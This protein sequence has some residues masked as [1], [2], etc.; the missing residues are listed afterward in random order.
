MKAHPYPRWRRRLCAALLSACTL[1]SVA[2]QPLY[3]RTA[4][5]VSTAE[6]NSLDDRWLRML[7]LGL[8]DADGNLIE[9]TAFALA[10]GR[11]ADSISA[12]LTLLGSDPDLSM[13]ITVLGSG[14]T[15][16]VEELLYALSIEYQMQSLSGS[17]RALSQQS[18]NDAAPAAETMDDTLRLSVTCSLDSSSL[19]INF[20]LTDAAGNPA[21]SDS[22]VTFG[23][24]L[25]GAIDGVFQDLELWK[26][27]SFSDVCGINEYVSYTIPAGS[28]DAFVYYNL[29]IL[30]QRIEVLYDVNDQL[31]SQRPDLLSGPLVFTVQ[32][33][34]LQGAVIEKQSNGKTLWLNADTKTVAYYRNR[35]DLSA[36]SGIMSDQTRRDASSEVSAAISAASG[37]SFSRVSV[38]DPVISLAD[39]LDMDERLRMAYELGVT[40]KV[41]AR[42]VYAGNGSFSNT[43][44]APV[45]IRVF[46]QSG[47][48]WVECTYREDEHN[49]DQNTATH[50]E[51]IRNLVL[52]YTVDAN[53]NI[54]FPQ[55]AIGETVNDANGSINFRYVKAGQ[56][57]LSTG[58]AFTDKDAVAPSIVKS[59][60]QDSI[61][62]PGSSDLTWSVGQKIPIIVDIDRP[63][64]GSLS[65]LLGDGSAL[66]DVET[67]GVNSPELFDVVINRPGDDE[68]YK[69]YPISAKRTMLY[70]VKEF[71]NTSIVLSAVNGQY[72]SALVPTPDGFLSI[73]EIAYTGGTSPT[74]A[75]R[76]IR[77]TLPEHGITG[78]TVEM[79]D[80]PYTSFRFTASTDANTLYQQLFS[81]LADPSTATFSLVAV[82]DD[83]FANAVPFSI[84]ESADGQTVTL[85]AQKIFDAAYNTSVPHTVRMY[86]LRDGQYTLIRGT[87]YRFTQQQVTPAPADAF[88]I[89]IDSDTLY[90]TDAAAPQLTITRNG[91]RSWTYDSS[92]Q[93]YWQLSSEGIVFINDSLYVVPQKEGTVSITRMCRNGSNDT[94]LHTPCSNTLE[95]T[96][97]G[98]STPSIRFPA[99]A[100][101]FLTREG[102]DCTVRF[103]SNLASMAAEGDP[104]TL[105]LYENGVSVYTDTL[106]RLANSATIPGRFLTTLSQGET[107]AYTVTLQT[108]AAGK[109]IST[110]AGIIVLPQPV[111]ISLSLSAD[112]SPVKSALLDG[113]TLTVSWTVQ[114]LRGGSFSLTMESENES[115][116]LHS[117]TGA[118]ANGVYTGSADVT[119]SLH[120]AQALKEN[121]LLLARAKNDA[122]DA[123]GSDSA[124]VTVY[125]RDALDILVGGE[126]GDS[127]I[128]KN[129]PSDSGVSTLPTITNTAGKTLSG[130]DSAE[131]I[132]ALR[133]ELGLLESVSINAGQYS[134]GVLSDRIQWSVPENLQKI[135]TLNYRQGTMFEPLDSFP[136]LYYIPQTILTLCGLSD[137]TAEV[138]ASHN[139][140][141]A[142]SDTVRV[143]VETL[144]NKLYLFQFSPAAKTT[145]SYVD[146]KGVQKEL[147]SN[148]DGSLALYEPDGI[149]SDL[150]CYT[151]SGGEAYMGTLPHAA[152]RSGE[153][154]GVRGELYPL[155]A[156]SMRRAASAEIV[157]TKPDGSP[158]TGA[159]TLRGGVYRN[160][161]LAQNRDD[162]YCSMAR[163]TD[164]PGHPADQDGASDM[165]F[166]ADANGRVQLYL[167]VTQFVSANDPDPLGTREDIEYILELRADGYY[168]TL[169]TL[170]A[171]LT[172]SDVMRGGTNRVSLQE[173]KEEAFFIV[174]Q[175][176][177]YGTG[178]Q[179]PVTKNT[180]RVGPNLNYSTAVFSSTIMLWGAQASDGD[181]TSQLRLRDTR[182]P[183][184]SQTAV[185]TADA[186]YPF[187][188]IPLLENT[189]TLDETLF[190]YFGEDSLRGEYRIIDR[191]GG[192]IGGVLSVRPKFV[193]MLNAER[194]QDSDN[195]LALMTKIGAFGSVDGL[196]SSSDLLNTASDG[197]IDAAL[198]FVTKMGAETGVV[199]CV[200]T[201]TEDPARFTGYFWT[202]MNTLKM[203]DLDYDDN[204]I[205]I[206][207]N[208]LQMQLNDTFSISDFKSMADGSYFEDRSNLYGAIANGVIGLPVSL[209]LEGW[210]STEICFNAASGEW[211][212]L[213]TGGGLTAAA[214]MQYEAVKDIVVAP[215]IP[216]TYSVKLRGGVVVDFKTAI[217]YA[218]ELSGE[219][220]ADKAQSVNDYLTALR[221]N[222]YIELFG[223]LGRGK[224]GFTLKIGSFGTLQLNN[225]NRFLT[226]NYL[227]EEKLEGQ[228]LR[229]DGEIGVKFAIGIGFI[230]VEV[231]LVSVGLGKGWTFNGWD[232]INEYWNGGAEGHSLRM[233]VSSDP[234]YVVLSQDVVLQ[235]R[236]YLDRYV[237]TWNDGSTPA[238]LRA[239]SYSALSPL[240]ENAYAYS[241]PMITRDGSLMLFLSDEGSKNVEDT[242]LRFTR[243]ASAPGSFQEEGAV[244]DDGSLSGFA[245]Y[246]DYSFDLDGAAGFAGA[247]WMRQS[248]S[249]GLMAGT[250]ITFEQQQALLSG[251]EVMAAIW[252]GREWRVE[253]LTDNGLREDSPVIAASEGHAVAVWRSVQSGEQ[254]GETVLDRI[255]YRVYDGIRWGET[256]T[257]YNGGSGSVLDLDAA[258][259]NDGS[260][261]VAYTLE[262]E[263]GT[264]VCYSLLDAFAEDP[265]ST[266]RTVCVSE[267]G[268]NDE[269]PVLTTTYKDG[270]YVFALGWHASGTDSGVQRHDIGLLVFD[271]SGVPENDLP[272]SLSQA[273]ADSGFD[274]LFTLSG[275]ADSIENLY[276]LFSDSQAGSD[277]LRAIRI[278]RSGDVYLPSAALE[279]CAM[280]EK[281]SIQS[282]SAAV[283]PDNQLLCAMLGDQILDSF[284]VKKYTYT[285]ESGIEHKITA[286]V[287]DTV[288][289]LYTPCTPM[290]NR[291]EV[292][293]MM[294]D[295]LTLAPHTPTPITFTVRN[296][297]M[298]EMTSVTVQLGTT[299]QRFSCQLLPGESAVLCAL[300]TPGDLLENVPYSC[301]ADF[302]DGSSASDSG[303]LYLDYPD[304]GISGVSVLRQ[305][306]GERLLHVS[307]YNASAATLN[308]PGRSVRLG[309][310]A[311]SDCT[312]PMDGKYFADGVP[313][314]G[315]TLTLSDSDTL[316]AIDAGVWT[317]AINFDAA[318]YVSDNGWSEIP[319]GGIRLFIKAEIV[320]N[321]TVLPEPDRFNNQLTLRLDSLLEQRGELVSVDSSVSHSESGTSA[322]V[323]L[324][325][326]SMQGAPAG[327]LIAALYDE[328]GNLLET[329][330][331]YDG[332]LLTL[333]CEEVRSFRF[334]FSQKGSYVQL[335]YTD[336][337]L[338]D[339]ASA[340]VTGI[341]LEGTPLTL[342]SFDENHRA[343]LTHLA[344]GSYALSVLTADPR[345]R[346]LIDGVPAESGAASIALPGGKK[347]IS[348]KIISP[349]GTSW[350]G[351]TLILVS[352]ADAPG[353]LFDDLPIITAP[354]CTL[355]FESNGGSAIP[356]ITRAFRT[357]LSLNGI[358]PTRSGYRFTG[359]Y[360]DE[361][362]TRRVTNLYLEK[363][364]TVYAGWEAILPDTPDDSG[365]VN[366]F[367][368]VR[369][370]DWF[371]ED[372]LYVC[373]N[374]LMRGVSDTRFD[375]DAPTTRGMLVTVLY[376]MAGEPA[377]GTCSFTDVPDGAY[378]R[379]AAAWAQENGLVNGYGDG[380]FGPDDP[381]TREQLAAILYRRALQTG[382]AA[383]GGDA[384]LTRF[385]DLDALAEYAYPAMRWAC[386]NGLIN[387][388]GDNR[389]DPRGEASRCQ[390]AA[391]LHRMLQK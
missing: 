110:T 180:S 71:D 312:V 134:W 272:L 194:I 207:P 332:A 337:V 42:L 287:P 162:A 66:S 131:A 25:F 367:E 273:L 363:D 173:A 99:G 171:S 94:A 202:G 353:G 362:L 93:Y 151:E 50:F 365:R 310:Y 49:P 81:Q 236:E 297:G 136:Y 277:T 271:G 74:L 174:R 245:G 317:Q 98:G 389:L 327:N 256:R 10:D 242:R 62:I 318:A 214:E 205:S 20:N 191:S 306:N 65:L 38:V 248:A 163:F 19:N 54:A 150:R 340:L 284:E 321:G 247:V 64:T 231:T 111:R 262:D 193:N 5:E 192:D 216:L 319:T 157:L 181:F 119:L 241:N 253:R 100:D 79:P 21:A 53:G 290:T 52:P 35:Y 261:A 293:D 122:D 113:D 386:G 165:R 250:P 11:S 382:E 226:K 48:E 55:L 148:D 24:G 308:R 260:T 349:D 385:A 2:Q 292:A 210:F 121:V 158:Y 243:P 141:P 381:I 379:D 58:A 366:P 294:A 378:Y 75:G 376:R 288:S 267:N 232:D 195:L 33:A 30:Q 13:E 143:R 296:A 1:F 291:V 197:I 133:S 9:D 88:E 254:L 84:G 108:T 336:D 209:A 146:G 279:V 186:T 371:F 203:D 128:L 208:F 323:T 40:D 372:V 6:D 369:E 390:I 307:L 101:T 135:L 168:P 211:E 334:D 189:L 69:C 264:R 234:G 27:I 59:N 167:D 364:L 278:V 183:F 244:L 252:N 29:G 356:S 190:D 138:S 268:R 12:L 14:Q 43:V 36:S 246:G 320:E 23:L 199:R 249:L 169:I 112:G 184:P 325:C 285:D 355:R 374:G 16:T 7:E 329:L 342:D 350:A 345:A 80:A 106:S 223:G 90:L 200:L 91:Q 305:E 166:Y 120:D 4:F 130:L 127:F 45:S 266:V 145:I 258:M 198:G 70:E 57:Q 147:V 156:V 176:V 182:I 352:D 235:S 384:D 358:L 116:V 283:L 281:T 215:G 60:G 304:A 187:S 238:L 206:E 61:R 220:D 259:L 333:G 313:G 142:L 78:L 274:G 41:R 204:G 388:V 140:L 87:S 344:P 86:V 222:A 275:G 160:R 354:D 224:G 132:A 380:R 311:D 115:R 105:T 196:D 373:E 15:V 298:A 149:A 125:H 303:T 289:N 391:I 107:P 37:A 155:N 357:I 370:S 263:T 295:F 219:W 82:L 228:Y 118:P 229:L 8:T 346:V 270:R 230:N 343:V 239:D 44:S 164:R 31:I 301:T 269:N 286:E 153:G 217:R 175:T 46:Y 383:P 351:Y 240:M 178:R 103:S 328:N 17:L 123:Y 172:E 251:G 51:A 341:Y 179:I 137:G 218:N 314:S 347:Q 18:A 280:P 335:R 83:D 161:T 92:E 227:Q 201:P 63:V 95:L 104:I 255:L 282:L 68:K 322:E 377:C 159:V 28:S 265:A 339:D 96:V 257:L 67:A 237:R 276:V 225:E 34:D 188:S 32:I 309:V 331:T 360:S 102:E 73:G 154:N 77:S 221:I 170:D 375:P 124:L 368:D 139:A 213:M 22:D 348:I 338:L 316:K 47:S 144:K 233:A 302:A 315:Y 177:D 359:W 117:F 89:S 324:S 326:N 109:T 126:S 3:A 185:D 212:I 300:Y 72:C 26:G 299:T 361:A 39:T 85:S 129:N 76:K 152:L 330:Q 387:G 114:N 56:V 97:K